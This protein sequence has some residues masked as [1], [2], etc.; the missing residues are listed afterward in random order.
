MNF[1]LDVKDKKDLVGIC[2]STWFN[3]IV[4]YNGPKP[5]NIAEILSGQDEWGSFDQ[6]HYWSEPAVGYYR[7]DDKKVIRHHMDLLG[8]AGIDFIILDNTNAS[9]DWDKGKPGDYWD[10]EPMKGGHGDTYYKWLC[11]YVRAYK[12]HQ[13]CPEL[14]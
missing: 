14:V 6:F 12:A 13:K 2:Y 9:P 5:K 1:G 11:E 10:I 4:N 3:P 7:S 8:A